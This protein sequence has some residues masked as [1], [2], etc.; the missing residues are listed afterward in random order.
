MNLSRIS[1]KLPHVDH[2]GTLPALH[3]QKL[4]DFAEHRGTLPDK[5]KLLGQLIEQYNS[6]NCNV[7]RHELYKTVCKLQ[8]EV[9]KLRDNDYEND[10][11]INAAPFLLKYHN[12]MEK[13]KKRK[14]DIENNNMKDIENKMKDSLVVESE[15]DEDEE[16][17][18]KNINNL[19][20]F[21]KKEEVTNKGKI[22][23]E[24]QSYCISGNYCS[25]YLDT[26]SE[27]DKLTCVCGETRIVMSREATAVCP[28]CG[29]CISFAD[30][31][32]P[33]EYRPEVEILSP[34]ALSL[35]LKSTMHRIFRHYSMTS[36]T[37]ALYFIKSSEINIAFSWGKYLLLLC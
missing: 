25:N 15:D 23:R 35:A 31:T 5:E 7:D 24:Y 26:K 8:T 2:R 20:K 19:T 32:G 34:F 33:M 16:Y 37:I 36:A 30:D 29:N 13:S 9:I 6:E 10:Y 1:K 28:K 21:V 4:I 27:I 18:K 22:Y 14:E 11:L 17:N 3:A 12:E